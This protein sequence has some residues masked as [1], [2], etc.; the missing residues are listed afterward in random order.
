MQKNEKS[1]LSDSKALNTWVN[2]NQQHH[3]FLLVGAGW[4]WGG[5]GMGG[6]F[7]EGVNQLVDVLYLSF[8]LVSF[9]GW[10]LTYD[11]N[12]KEDSNNGANDDGKINAIICL[13]TLKHKQQH[14]QQNRQVFMDTLP[15]DTRAIYTH[16]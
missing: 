16:T 4:R 9:H 7:G 14:I 3:P 1:K 13:R 11:D 15:E 8:L 10:K 5:G 6:G 2:P 12:E